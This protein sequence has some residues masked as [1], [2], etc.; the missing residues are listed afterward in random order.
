MKT[1]KRIT[2]FDSG[3][4]GLSI[5]MEMQKS[6]PTEDYLYLSDKN[7]LPYGS[8]S[9]AFI[10][11]RIREAIHFAK[12]QQSDLLIIACHTASVV[13]L[14]SGLFMEQSLPIYYPSPSILQQNLNPIILLATPLSLKTRFFQRELLRI[15]RK[16]FV[17]IP[18]RDLATYIERYFESDSSST[19]DFW[20]K[21]IRN[22]ITREVKPKIE[23]RFK[24]VFPDILPACTHYYLI[25]THL[26]E[27][28]S[29]CKII[30]PLPAILDEI[31]ELLSVEKTNNDL[32]YLGD[33]RSISPI[34]RMTDPIRY[35]FPL[36]G[37]I[38]Y[39]NF[40]N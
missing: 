35:C 7:N 6:Y 4:G 25:S 39:F 17:S 2:I 38:R 32:D 18:L 33:S 27:L 31:K 8:K 22:E 10:L 36:S 26:E 9:K 19:S 20:L 3:I 40:Q 29:P 37:K 28:L 21:K 13:A 14:N 34:L 5:L 16:N 15:G 24:G 11:K 23:K 1:R 30:N 12:E